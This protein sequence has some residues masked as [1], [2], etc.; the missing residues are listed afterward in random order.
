MCREGYLRTSSSEYS[1]DKTNLNNEYIHLTNNAVQKYAPNYG[2]HEDGN[3]LSFP[4]LKRYL[5]SEYPECDYER[6]ILQKMKYYAALTAASV[7]DN[8]KSILGK[9]QTKS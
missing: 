2:A 5:Q 4:Y 9:T 7:R 3:Q 6:M 8:C 1:T